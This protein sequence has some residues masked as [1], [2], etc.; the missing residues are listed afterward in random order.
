MPRPTVGRLIGRV[1]RLPDHVPA[2][3]ARV[4]LLDPSTNDSSFPPARVDDTGRFQFVDVPPGWYHPI[5]EAGSM[6]VYAPLRE[7]IRIDAGRDTELKL[8]LASY[9]GLEGTGR[10]V[11]G[12]VRD[13]VTGLP[14]EGAWV[15]VGF[16]DP[17][18]LMGAGMPPWESRTDSEGR[19][20]LSGVPTVQ[21]SDGS[22]GLYPIVCTHRDHR[23]GGTGS[24]VRGEL[25]PIR[26]AD[27]PP[28]EVEILLEPGA[29]AR[30]MRGRV[31]HQGE[32]VRGVPVAL[33]FVDPDSG[34]PVPAPSTRASGLLP[35]AMVPGAVL[36]TDPSG[37]F[38]FTDLASGRYRVHAAYL[39]DDG[40]VPGTLGS[41]ASAAVTVGTADVENVVVPVLP[42]IRLLSPK[43]LEVVA[44]VRPALSWEPVVGAARYLVLF[45]R[46]NSFV[47]SQSVM[48]MESSV[49]LP[50]GYYRE[51]DQARW[52]VQVYVDDL[53]VASSE[54]VGSFIIGRR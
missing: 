23:N 5:I 1:E 4:L 35:M 44:T 45:S 53:L 40:W 22:M 13:T 31:V 3:G 34:G 41:G 54:E 24:L 28:L 49:L 16:T 9:P 19:F 48:T 51:G 2:I 26:P 27:G 36:E 18:F 15:S 37:E 33:T 32:G 43:R 10:P 11:H 7:A 50:P 29:G 30:S 38:E 8:D 20:K 12:I 39:A 47:L 52:A 25:L 17:T 46:A 14:I 21:L 6:F 42:G